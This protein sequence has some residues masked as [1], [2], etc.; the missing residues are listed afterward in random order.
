MFTALSVGEPQSVEYLE[1]DDE[2][3]TIE[4]A[5]SR[6]KL[7]VESFGPPPDAQFVPLPVVPIPGHLSRPFKT[8]GKGSR[9]PPPPK[10]KP[11][12]RPKPVRPLPV[13]PEVETT[14]PLISRPTI[15]PVPITTRLPVEV[16]TAKPFEPTKRP[17]RTSTTPQPGRPTDTLPVITR[18]TYT[19][20]PLTGPPR[21]TTTIRPTR[22][23]PLVHSTHILEDDGSYFFE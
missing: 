7:T 10:R 21:R 13:R 4:D 22:P 11:S 19:K 2:P 5:D 6:D 3:L 14:K 18:P 9:P 1:L 20:K 15:R 17:I 16:I 23:V 12:K 8:P